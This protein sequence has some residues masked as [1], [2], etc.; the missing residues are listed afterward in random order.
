[1]GMGNDRQ[2]TTGAA[3]FSGPEGLQGRGAGA[4]RR[5][6]GARAARKTT[7]A[8]AR[9]MQ[10]SRCAAF[11]PAVCGNRYDAIGLVFESPRMANG[12]NISGKG[13]THGFPLP[14]ICVGV[15]YA[16]YVPTV[17][18]LKPGMVAFLEV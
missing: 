10:R 17:A 4:R 9:Y 2:A 8:P 14:A 1:M 11:V 18:N 12:V 16:C 6:P 7:A 3:W 13:I 15:G 5:S